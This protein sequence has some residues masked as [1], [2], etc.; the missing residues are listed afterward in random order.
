VI[1]LANLIKLNQTDESF[2][3]PTIYLITPSKDGI[4]S[5]NLSRTIGVS[6]NAALRLKHKLQHVMKKQDDAWPLSGFSQI[7]DSYLGG[8]NKGGKR[9]R[10]ASGKH[11]FLLLLPLTKK[12]TPFKY[13]SLG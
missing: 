8:K 10:G 2:S 5:L 9:G 12:A 6:A 13:V 11:L 3:M 4:S 7:D 1:Y